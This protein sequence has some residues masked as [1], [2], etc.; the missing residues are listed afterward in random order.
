[1]AFLRCE[2]ASESLRMATAVDVILPDKGDLSEVKTLYL[3]HGLTD[4]CTGW[5]RY[6]AVERYVRERG[7]AVVL[8]E[9]QRSF[10]TDMAYGLPYFTYVSEELPAVC[11]RMFGL[12]AAREQNYIFG[13]SMGGYGANEMRAHLPRPLRGRGELFGRL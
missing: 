7:L 10:Y 8:P 5:T 11:R 9:V 2:I 13:L 4:D 3:L 1:M 6:T 12:G